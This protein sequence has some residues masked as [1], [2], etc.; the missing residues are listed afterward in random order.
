MKNFIIIGM[1]GSGKSTAGK[2]AAKSAGKNFIDIDEMITKKYGNINDIF[3]NLGEEVF[4]EYE[5]KALKEAVAT[6]GNVI[7]SGGGIVE[8]ES[9][10]EI[11]KNNTVIFIDRDLDLIMSTIDSNTRPLLKGRKQALEE[12]YDRRYKKYL[13]A[14]DHHVA[15]NS[16]FMECVN[17]IKDII[18]L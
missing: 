18:D 9:N 3:K 2:A 6:S 8:S 13:N 7:S 12:L 11:L 10:L 14:M 1:P 16:T 4:R 15:N 5:T 17:K